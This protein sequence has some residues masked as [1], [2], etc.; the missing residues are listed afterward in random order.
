LVLPSKLL[1]LGGLAFSLLAAPALAATPAI[2]PLPVQMQVNPGVFTLCP[3]QPIPGAPARAT[4]QILVDSPSLATGQ[5]L[6]M[7]LFRSTG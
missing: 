4:Q 5:Y 2:I 7:M 6:A 1:G 3:G